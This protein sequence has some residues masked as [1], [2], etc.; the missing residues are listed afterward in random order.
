MPRCFEWI[1]L[2]CFAVGSVYPQTADTVNSSNT[3]FKAKVDVVLVDVV[4]T[5]HNDEPINGLQK[6][7]FQILEQG[8][9]QTIASFE[10]HKGVPDQAMMPPLPPHIYT[11]YPLGKPADSINVLLLDSLNTPLG[12]QSKVRLQMLRSLKSIPAGSHIAIFTLSSGLRMVQGFTSDSSILLAAVNKSRVQMS[13]LLGGEPADNL[14]TQINKQITATGA[15]MPAAAVASMETLQQF[16][17]QTQ[18]VQDRL[19]MT[20]TLESLQ[21]LANYLRGFPGRKNV[22]WF[23]GSFP[24]AIIPGKGVQNYEFGLSE[25]LELR[26]AVNMLAA[27]QVAIYPIAPE[28]LA[29]KFDTSGSRVKSVSK[30]AWR[31]VQDQD[32]VEVTSPTWE[33]D[34]MPRENAQ[35]KA[36]QATMYE[37]AKDTGGEAFYNTNGL[38]EAL[39]RAISDGAHYYTI[40]YSPT[41]K[42]ADGRY[43]TIDVK[44]LKGEYKLAYRHGYFADEAEGA[45]KDASQHARDPL[46]PLMIGGIPD[47][48]QII[49]KIRVLPLPPQPGSKAAV[50]GAKKGLKGPLTRYGVDFA[51]LLHDLTF[52]VTTEGQRKA[53][54]EI[55]LVAYDQDGTPV[56]SI[57]K[58]TDISLSPRLYAAFENTGVQLHEEIDVPNADVY[59]RTGIYEIE[60]GKAGTLEVPLNQA[61]ASVAATK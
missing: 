13:P 56:N 32:L 19:R 9:P 51:V 4:V 61:A 2:S 18:N 37:I 20:R 44:V 52:K 21:Q 23:S 11:N 55:A 22:I 8:K 31:T 43:R 30:N 5:D 53:K 3:T 14:D 27:A 39:A 47:A 45:T 7:D 25:Q 34:K 54:L 59:L 24:L 12:D 35:Q 57:V 41:D 6:E 1:A 26:K 50:T 29:Q 17:N 46:Q 38:N 33:T 48:T 10:E 60:T 42:R 15:G 36:H 28:G 16:Q 40:S 49:Y 58:S